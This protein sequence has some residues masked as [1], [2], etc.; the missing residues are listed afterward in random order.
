M[1]TKRSDAHDKRGNST[2]ATLGRRGLTDSA[3]VTVGG[4]ITLGTAKGPFLSSVGTGQFAD[5]KLT[6][7]DEASR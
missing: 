1:P 7:G 5:L 6:G 3:V 2:Q 4:V